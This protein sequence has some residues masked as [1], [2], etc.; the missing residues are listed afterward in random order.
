MTGKAPGKL[1][2]A[3]AGEAATIAAI[4]EAAPSEI[5]GDDAAVLDALTP[6][7]QGAVI[8]GTARRVYRFE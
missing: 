6:D 8:G 2:V 1:T 4:R 5:N 7:E 3:Q